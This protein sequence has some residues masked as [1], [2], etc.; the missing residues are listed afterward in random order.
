M[1]R[2]DTCF[3]RHVGPKGPKEGILTVEIAGDRPPR[4]GEKNASFTV[5]RGP[6][7]R[8]A[9][10]APTLAGDRSPRYGCRGAC[11]CG[12]L[13]LP[14]RAVPRAIAGGIQKMPELFYRVNPERGI[15]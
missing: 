15:K 9:A 2:V 11:G 12:G 1:T 5:G 4:Y 3:Y 8:H 14:G 6:V 7:P 10:I 13:T